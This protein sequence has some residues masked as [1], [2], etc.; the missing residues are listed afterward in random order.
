M[1]WPRNDPDPLEE[2]RRQLAEKER[3]VA[4]QLS[5]LTRQMHLSGEPP[6]PPAAKPVEPPVWRLEE[7]PRRVDPM[8]VRR[9]H[10]ARQT[11][12]DMLVFFISLGVLLLVVTI[13]LW[14]AYVHNNAPPI[15]I[16][17]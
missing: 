17:N 16:S 3:L 7:E 5:Q 11:Q 4:E 1:P 15:G 9:R 14:V 6:P 12:R 2:R 10:L 13:L 8:P